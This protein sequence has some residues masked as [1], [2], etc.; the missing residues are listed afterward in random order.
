M[1]IVDTEVERDLYN[2]Q[3]QRRIDK[4]AVVSIA[5][6]YVYRRHQTYSARP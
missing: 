3:T 5:L 4:S 2:G 6:A 1:C